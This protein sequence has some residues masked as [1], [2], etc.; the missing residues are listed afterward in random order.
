MNF[1]FVID[2]LLAASSQPGK[3][4]RLTYYLD[5]YRDSGIKVLISL[6]K[7]IIVP[8]NYKKDFLLY[9][10]PIDEYETPSLI[11]VDKIVDT[12]IKHIKKGEPVNINCAAGISNSSMILIAAIMKYENA[13]YE[14]AFKKVSDS[15]F[16][17]DEPEKE[18]FLK[19]YEL[20]LEK[21]K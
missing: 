1:C 15:R 8:D 5:L 17:L 19:D 3:N 13:N 6:Y 9:H 20:F 16:A 14:D 18:S 12:I 7:K 11:E 21:K 10:M 2:G 4:K